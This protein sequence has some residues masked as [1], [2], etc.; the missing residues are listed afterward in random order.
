MPSAPVII[1]EAGKRILH[2]F[3]ASVSE[4]AE[5][6][7]RTIGVPLNRSG[8]VPVEADLSIPG[9]SGELRS[10]RRPVA[11][12]YVTWSRGARLITGPWRARILRA[13]EDMAD[14]LDSGEWNP[15]IGIGLAH[16]AR[17]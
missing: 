14:P 15:K 4:R 16:R 17:E 2:S 7:L 3:T 13:A 12:A 11:C 6:S 8:R 5:A 10:R 9:A 1:L